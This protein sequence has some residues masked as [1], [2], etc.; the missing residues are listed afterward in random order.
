MTAGSL[1]L[2]LIFLLVPTL[3]QP[4]EVKRVISWKK[5]K[6]RIHEMKYE[7]SLSIKNPRFR[8]VIKD[9][10][11]R[12]RY[13]LLVEP[14]LPSRPTDGIESWSVSLIPEHSGL[15][16][17]LSWED[18][19]L[20]KPS[21]DPYQDSF[22]Y[23]DLIGWFSPWCDEEESKK[24][25]PCRPNNWFLQKRIIKVESFYITL[26]V[27]QYQYVTG[28]APQLAEVVLDVTFSNNS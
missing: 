7:V 5:G 8:A 19:N 6:S 22:G 28:K 27:R 18:V 16:K 20:L 17:L 14:F 11:E 2:C 12:D 15:G 4:A 21:N 9:D 10:K 3:A 24:K 1:Q 26:Q 13:V 25:N 23:D